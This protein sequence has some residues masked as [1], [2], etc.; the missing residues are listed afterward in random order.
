VIWIVFLMWFI[1][2]AVSVYQAKYNINAA[3]YLLPSRSWELLSGCLVAIIG[4]RSN[5]YLSFLGMAMVIF[6]LTF[7]SD[8]IDH[9]SFLTLIPVIGTCLFII[10]AH[11]SKDICGK[12]LSIKPVVFIGMISYSLYLWHQP[13]FAFY[14]IRF[15]EINTF[16]GLAL[17]FV[18][19]LVA[20]ISYYFIEKPFRKGGYNLYK[21][22]LATTSFIMIM[23]FS[24]Y[25]HAT[26]GDISRLSLQAQ[27]IYM[28]FS[29]PEFRRLKGNPGANL[30][31]GIISESCFLRDPYDACSNGDSSWVTIGDSYAGTLDFY[32]SKV[33]L[34]KGH[35]LMSLTYE[36][37]PFVNDFWF[38]NVPECVEVNKR[39][40]NIIKSFKE[41]KNI[42][43]SANYY[44][45]REGKL[46]T[47]N[48][49][50]DGRNNLSYGIR[51]NEDEV[52]QSFSKNIVTLQALGHNVIVIYPI[53]SV[54]EDAKKMYL[55]LIT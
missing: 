1:S 13:I 39:R 50:E 52:W 54:T 40:W 4:R 25:I 36:Q 18:S 14:R 21:K 15:Y 19:I 9:P 17:I 34:E 29:E 51:A 16:T 23:T 22:I 45:F 44:F 6:S 7:M 12:T 42:I 43:I 20:V 28:N 11:H 27:N 41:R 37:C 53:P 3:F 30:R 48:P 47:N 55:S 33:L 24:Y 2:F 35:G 38:G 32:L 31:S 10:F 46:A 49:L 26:N 8:K 5:K